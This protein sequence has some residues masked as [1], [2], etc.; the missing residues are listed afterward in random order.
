MKQQSTVLRSHPSLFYSIAMKNMTGDTFE[1]YLIVKRENAASL[2]YR[3]A[4]SFAKSH[5]STSGHDSQ[6]NKIS[7]S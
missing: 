2:N 5:G 6:R 1:I 7:Y 3:I 4:L